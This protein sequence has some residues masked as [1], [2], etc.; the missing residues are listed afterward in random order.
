LGASLGTAMSIVS[1]VFL[2]LIFTAFLLMGRAP[3]AVRTGAYA[4]IDRH[5][6]RY[7]AIKVAL[8]ALTGI[9]VAGT[10][11][12]LGLELAGIFGLLAFFLNFI[13]SVGSIV[14]TL[15][16]V[17]LAIAQYENPWMVLP[18]VAVPGAIQIA[19]GNGIE[20]KMM[21]EGLNL[22]PVTVL[23]AL[24]FWGLLWGVVGMVLAA[25]LTAV[26]RIVLLHFETV[27]PIAELMAGKLP[28]FASREAS[29]P[30]LVR[31]QAGAKDEKD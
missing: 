4:E 24:A 30:T 27:R 5:V 31:G 13:P 8:S 11:Y 21:G 7:I 15:L 18:V 26:V 2:V 10:L 20:P 1:N 25:P 28:E 14:A 3:R 19:I 23:L 22:H 9:L 17:P 6:R 29:A 16:P 12:L